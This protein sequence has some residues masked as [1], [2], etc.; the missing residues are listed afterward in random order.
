MP[1]IAEQESVLNGR[2]RF[3]LYANGK[4]AGN[5]L[6]KSERVRSWQE[7]QR[8]KNFYSDFIQTFLVLN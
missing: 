7:S 8:L 3:L 5:C 1:Q 6:M 2:G 4:G